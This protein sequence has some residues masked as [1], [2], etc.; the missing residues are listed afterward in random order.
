M[1]A[2]PNLYMFVL[3]ERYRYTSYISHFGLHVIT[4]RFNEV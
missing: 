4:V 1:M 3:E 2:K